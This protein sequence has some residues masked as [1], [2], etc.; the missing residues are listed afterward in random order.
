[1]GLDRWFLGEF[2]LRSA[3][4]WPIAYARQAVEVYNGLRP[5]RG[6]G[7]A[8]NLAVG[9]RCLTLEGKSRSMRLWRL[10]HDVID[11]AAA[12]A[13]HARMAVVRLLEARLE[14][15]A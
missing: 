4:Q 8:Y 5:H 12:I 11:M 15:C 3:A 2:P 13:R 10:R 1:L 14:A 6:I 7:L 9:G